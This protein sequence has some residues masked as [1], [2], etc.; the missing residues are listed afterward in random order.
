ML[1][2]G[3][4]VTGTTLFMLMMICLI[5]TCVKRK[6][7]NQTAIAPTM[8]IIQRRISATAH[9]SVSSQADRK[10][11]I[12]DTS[13]EVSEESEPVPYFRKVVFTHQTLN[14]FYKVWFYFQKSTEETARKISVEAVGPKKKKSITNNPLGS[15]SKATMMDQRDRSLT[16]MIPRAKYHPPTKSNLIDVDGYKSKSSSNASIN[17]SKLINYLDASPSSSK[18]KNVCQF[19]ITFY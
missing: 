1:L 12:Q 15:F 16:V 8:N 5:I 18:S 19:L 14:Y 10:A 4:V 17:Q 6:R 9:H 3:L 2:F 13:S 7:V 11:M